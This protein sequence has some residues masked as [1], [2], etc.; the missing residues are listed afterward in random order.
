[1]NFIKD[2]LFV[3]AGGFIGSAARYGVWCL[4]DKHALSEFPYATLTVNAA[5]SLIIGI[6]SV[7]LHDLHCWRLF[8][9]V[10]VLG[11]FTTFSSFSYDTLVL[12]NANHIFQAFLNVALSILLCLLFVYIGF[13]TGKYF[14]E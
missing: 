11:G 14:F 13:K 2:F 10:G 8:L 6:L 7:F 3:G 9:L 12:F 4:F 1:M 5:G